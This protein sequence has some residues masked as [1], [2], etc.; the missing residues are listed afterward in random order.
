MT[1][2]VNLS[3]SRKIRII[4][5]LNIISYN[6]YYLLDYCSFNTGNGQA[7][8]AVRTGD[9]SLGFTEERKALNFLNYLSIS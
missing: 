7:D 8:F 6:D 3:T 9:S 5:H 2:T 4:I 1:T